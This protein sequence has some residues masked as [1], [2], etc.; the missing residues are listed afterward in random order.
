[1]SDT[2]HKRNTA[3][4]RTLDDLK[5]VP[6]LRWWAIDDATLLGLTGLTDV[7]S[8]PQEQPPTRDQRVKFLA[9][10]RPF[11]PSLFQQRPEETTQI[12]LSRWKHPVTGALPA[13]PYAKE[14]LNLSE[15]SWF[16]ANEPELNAFLKAQAETGSTFS[17]IAKQRETEA[18]NK[19]LRDMPYGEAEHAENI[20]RRPANMTELD[21]FRKKVGADVADFYKREAETPIRLPWVGD[22]HHTLMNKMFKKAPELHELIKKSIPLMQEWAREDLV[23]CEKQNA[24]AQARAKA[25]QEILGAKLDAEREAR[26]RRIDALLAGKTISLL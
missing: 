3:I 21:E 8:E 22:Q 13:N 23:E 9:S 15:Q 5:H 25:A 4:G 14:T 18:R 16:A 19:A 12:D 7:W 10:L 2:R 20:F 26:N 6:G 1:M 17:S 24:E 11:V